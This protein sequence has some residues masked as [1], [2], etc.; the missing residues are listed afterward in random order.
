MGA[1]PS[2]WPI[3]CLVDHRGGPCKI[4]RTAKRIDHVKRGTQCAPYIL[5]LPA[6][7]HFELFSRDLSTLACAGNPS[8]SM[9]NV[10]MT[11]WRQ[12]FV[13]AILAASCSGAPDKALP[14]DGWSGVPLRAL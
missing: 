6:V 14:R 9:V 12:G 13:A 11:A 5:G 4:T 8:C 2:C 3:S 1:R 10:A 7:P